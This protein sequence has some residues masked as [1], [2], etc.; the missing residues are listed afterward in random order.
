MRLDG[1]HC[2]SSLSGCQG[3][4][5]ETCKQY[6]I[7]YSYISTTVQIQSRRSG[8]SQV[9]KQCTLTCTTN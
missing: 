1:A 8:D 9:P 2:N 6:F 4:S 7:D 3:M 5:K